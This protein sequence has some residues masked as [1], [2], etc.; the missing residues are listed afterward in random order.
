MSLKKTIEQGITRCVM[1]QM[2]G[3]PAA[4]DVPVVVDTY[5]EALSFQGLCDS[6]HKRVVHAFRVIMSS[7]SDFPTPVDIR[8]AV[9]KKLHEVIEPSKRLE[10]DKKGGDIGKEHMAKWRAINAGEWTDKQP[11]TKELEDKYRVDYT[12]SPA[13]VA[14]KIKEFLV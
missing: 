11:W 1:C 7:K 12:P 3:A 14:R 9:P 5:Y 10:R 8:N 2:K 6:D 4:E 13:E